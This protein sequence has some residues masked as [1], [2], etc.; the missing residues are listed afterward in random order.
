[1]ASRSPP[2]YHYLRSFERDRPPH[3][4]QEVEVGWVGGSMAE[5]GKLM[6]GSHDFSL[7]IW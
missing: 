5:K 2:S 3:L 6:L 7:G 1:M 4:F